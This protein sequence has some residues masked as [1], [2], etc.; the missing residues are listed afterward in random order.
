MSFDL[1]AS[2]RRL[3]PQRRSEPVGPRPK[4]QQSFVDGATP[5]PPLLIDSCVYID[6]LQGRTPTEVDDLLTLRIINHSTVALTE[7]THLLGRLDP[8]HPKTKTVLDPLRRVLAAI[9][10][11]R[12]GTPSA[13]A[14]AEAGMLAGLSARLGTGGGQLTER[15]FDAILLV[16]ALEQGSILLTRNIHD[17]D[18]LQQ[19]R[20][21]ARVLFYERT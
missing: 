15:R 18:L 7:L 5:G 6:V 11:H 21:A 13:Q 4:D 9:P 14:M 1:A 10:A 16:H 17:F 2:E 8:G 19:L 3:R 12:L 20:P